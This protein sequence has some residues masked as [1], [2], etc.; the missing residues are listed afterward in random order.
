MT[1]TAKLVNALNELGEQYGPFQGVTL[2]ANGL[3]RAVWA[4]HSENVTLAELEHLVRARPPHP[5][6]LLKL[7]QVR[8][9][10]ARNELAEARALE[11]EVMDQLLAHAYQQCPYA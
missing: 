4:Q 7:Q 10:K 8:R 3:C 5:D 11:L 6:W 2:M 1:E 9:H